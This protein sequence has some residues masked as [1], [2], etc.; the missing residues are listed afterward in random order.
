MIY[1][2]FLPCSQERACELYPEPFES[3]PTFK[4]HLNICNDF[5][6]SNLFLR[7]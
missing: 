1:D 5:I 2:N 4:L 7:H 3:S 6:F